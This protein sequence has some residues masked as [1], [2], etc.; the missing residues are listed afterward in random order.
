[1]RNRKIEMDG[2]GMVECS[3]KNQIERMFCGCVKNERGELCSRVK[4]IWDEVV[5]VFGSR[6]V[7]ELK[8]EV[9][10]VMFGFGRLAGYM[11][12]RVY[13]KM[14]YDERHVRKIEKRMEEY[15]CV[16]SRRHLVNGMCSCLAE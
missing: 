13:V 10:D 14:W 5:E 6:S 11:C 8:D 15:G 12:G 2:N 7:E 3:F 16:R 4:E 1:M 9:S